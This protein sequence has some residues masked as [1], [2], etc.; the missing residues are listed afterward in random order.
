MGVP[1]PTTHSR[2][3]ERFLKP[4]K[5]RPVGGLYRRFG[6]CRD[7]S[8]LKADF[9]GE[10]P[11]L[12]FL[13]PGADCVLSGADGSGYVAKVRAPAFDDAIPRAYREAGALPFREVVVPGSLP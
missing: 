6:L 2:E 3:R 11:G 7:R 8:R 4:Y 1:G 5:N 13:V 12:G 9:G 10:V